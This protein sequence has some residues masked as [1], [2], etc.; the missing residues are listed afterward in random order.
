VVQDTNGELPVST[1]IEMIT[2]ASE[3]VVVCLDQTRHGLETGDVVTFKEVQG[4]TQLNDR[5]PIKI[6][7]LGTLPRVLV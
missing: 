6:K 2:Q 3:G 4:M 1:N 7:V 5:D